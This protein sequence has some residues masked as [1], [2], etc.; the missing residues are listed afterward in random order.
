M[1]AHI[2]AILVA[3]AIA[4]GLPSSPPTTVAPAPQPADSSWCEQL[5]PY[6]KDVSATITTY[7]DGAQVLTVACYID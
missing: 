7:A 4:L 1:F 5:G 3:L 6:L 2:I